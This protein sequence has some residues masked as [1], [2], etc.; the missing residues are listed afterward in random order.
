MPQHRPH[1]PH[2]VMGGRHHGDLL[3][4]RIVPLH[5]VPEGADR[6]GEPA[7]LPH[8]F[9]QVVPYDRR[10]LAGDVS[11]PVPVSRLV[12]GRHTAEVRADLFAVGEP[13]RVVEVGGHRLGRPQAD[14]GDGS[15]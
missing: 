8:R 10:A 11:Q 1:H 9:G 7:G 14:T 13:L 5:A 2:Q 12:L 4:L 3:A 6:R 15:Q